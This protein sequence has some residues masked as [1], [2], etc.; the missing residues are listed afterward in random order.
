MVRSLR[1]V[2]TGDL[3]F[4][5]LELPAFLEDASTGS[6]SGRTACEDSVLR[7]LRTRPTPCRPRR[8]R[9]R[10]GSA[11]IGL[12]PEHG[13]SGPQPRVVTGCSTS[14]RGR[15][16]A[17]WPLGPDPSAS[18]APGPCP[19]GRKRVTALSGNLN[20]QATVRTMPPAGALRLQDG[21]GAVREC[22]HIV[23]SV[24]EFPSR[25][26]STQAEPGRRGPWRPSRSYS[27]ALH[28]DAR[29]HAC[30][31]VCGSTE[32]GMGAGG[33]GGLGRVSA[34]AARFRLWG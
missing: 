34:D 32:D 30:S 19:W 27:G 3:P 16:S 5:L 11:R 4:Q 10:P 18:R 22:R 12:P 21:R 8:S 25:L 13:V 20:G 2:L 31:T 23:A 24:W 28:L 26:P 9:R 14:S 6:G 33:S 29:N 15:A 7:S 17:G 1:P